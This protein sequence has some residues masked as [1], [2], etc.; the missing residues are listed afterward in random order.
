M[1]VILVFEPGIEVHEKFTC[2]SPIDF[3]RVVVRD[4]EVVECNEVE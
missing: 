4:V 3:G 1:D 2:Q